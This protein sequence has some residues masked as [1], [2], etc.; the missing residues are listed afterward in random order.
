[1]VKEHLK[2][3]AIEIERGK[4]TL[5]FEDEKVLVDAIV[6]IMSKNEVRHINESLKTKA[7]PTTKIFIKEHKIFTSK[8]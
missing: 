6:F 8:G 5:I 2:K 4:I 1:M 7:I 3:P